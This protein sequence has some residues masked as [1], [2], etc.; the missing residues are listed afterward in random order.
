MVVEQEDGE[1]KAHVERSKC[2]VVVVGK[3]E[4]CVGRGECLNSGKWKDEEGRKAFH[5]ND[6]ET[7]PHGQIWK[8]SVRVVSR[9]GRLEAEA[10]ADEEE[11]RKKGKVISCNDFL[12]PA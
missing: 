10:E 2:F 1:T 5:S 11:C 4:G 9:N 3:W 7:E 12:V 6:S 8:A